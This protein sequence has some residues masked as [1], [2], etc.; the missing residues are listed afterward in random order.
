MISKNNKKAS[1]LSMNQLIG[2]FISVIAL[3]ILLSFLYNTVFDRY[4]QDIYDCSFFMVNVDGKP[5]Y[6]GDSLDE[7]SF[8]LINSIVHFCPSK[9][10]ELSNDNI[11]DSAK[12][13][14]SCYNLVGRGEDF[15]GANVED[16]SVCVHCGFIEVKDDISNFN[17]KFSNELSRD[18]YDFFFDDEDELF[19]TN[20]LFFSEDNL[21]DS[22]KEDDYLR[23][24]AYA[25]KPSVFVESNSFIDDVKNV[26]NE[27]LLGYSKFMGGLF[28]LSTITYF[29]SE[30]LTEG[31][32]GVI[33]EQFDDYKEFDANREINYTQGGSS[34]GCDIVIIPKKNYD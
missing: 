8:S 4:D 10:V 29:N 21:I 18:K 28:G 7:I 14:T 5:A 17:E 26:K 3:F 16:K 19:N 1:S 11:I 25:Y 27:F 6:F 20:T 34:L 13:V 31:F 23:V 33:I 22:V 15:F 2:V 9:D 24:L 32:S 30:S 12:L